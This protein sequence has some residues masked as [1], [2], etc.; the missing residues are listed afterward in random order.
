VKI[1]PVTAPTEAS[2][3]AHPDHDRW[4]KD[5]TLKM[6]VEHAKRVGIPLRYAE[7]ENQR[8][9]EQHDRMAAD[10]PAE[11]P[12]RKPIAQPAKVAE[13]VIRRPAQ[14]EK[15]KK[16]G[17]SPCGRCGTCI[18]CKREQ[19]AML[20]IARR[21]ESPA[22]DMLA[23]RMFVAALQSQSSIGKFKGLSRRDSDRAMTVEVESICDTSVRHL[24]QWR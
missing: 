6:E 10:R 13:G 1:S 15:I 22:L 20:I 23:L 4:F 5:T 17:L 19:R 8:L 3:P 9:L 12:K 21:K 11:K 16:V 14:P 24:G 7:A 2:D 18:V